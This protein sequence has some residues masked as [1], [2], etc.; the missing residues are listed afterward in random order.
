MAPDSW[1]QRAGRSSQ[2]GPV[3]AFPSGVPRVR[4]S[5]HTAASPAI[6]AAWTTEVAGIGHRSRCRR[7]SSRAVPRRGRRGSATSRRGARVATPRPAARPPWPARR[8][9]RGARGGRRPSRDRPLRCRRRGGA[10]RK[11]RTARFRRSGERRS[12]ATRSSMTG[13]RRPSAARIS[14]VRSGSGPA[15]WTRR[16]RWSALTCSPHVRQPAQVRRWWSTTSG[17]S[18]GTSPS[19]PADSEARTWVQS[20]Y[21]YRRGAAKSSRR[22]PARCRFRDGRH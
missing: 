8:C 5:N 2:Q 1:L 15:G 7:S 16:P 11:R 6:S 4:A 17:G 12:T 13:R 14:S 9:R 18:A 20:M 19:R 21:R 22:V 10:G 3:P